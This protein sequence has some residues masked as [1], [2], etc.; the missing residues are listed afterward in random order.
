MLRLS[1]RIILEA[2]IA[3]STRLLIKYS[4]DETQAKKNIS[5]LVAE[6]TLS[7]N[8]SKFFMG[9]LVGKSKGAA[10]DEK[11]RS[12]VKQLKEE[13]ANRMM[14]ILY[15]PQYGTMDLKFWLAFSKLKFL[16]L[17]M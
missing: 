5:I 12:Y 11:F 4:I 15:N 2:E 7:P 6:A 13:T 9:N 3:Q 14:A 16:K 10:E 17:S 8:D 1:Q